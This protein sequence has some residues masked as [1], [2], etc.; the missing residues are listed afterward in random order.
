MQGFKLALLG[1]LSGVK[2][3]DADDL[4]TFAIRQTAAS[5]PRV[6]H[7]ADDLISVSDAACIQVS[8]L[9]FLRID[10]CALGQHV[11][12]VKAQRYVRHVCR[13]CNMCS[14]HVQHMQ[15]ATLH[16]CHWRFLADAEH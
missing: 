14:I 1:Q 11:L 3:V 13:I 2:A 6:L 5:C 10:A 4:L 7:L 15:L 16:A 12:H 9:V 8:R